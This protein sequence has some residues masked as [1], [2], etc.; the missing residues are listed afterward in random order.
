MIYDWFYLVEISRLYTEY[1][2]VV[3]N[4]SNNLLLESVLD[5][6]ASCRNI[7]SNS[8]SLSRVGKSVFSFILKLKTRKTSLKIVLI[9]LVCRKCVITVLTQASSD[10]FLIQPCHIL[11]MRDCM[12]QKISINIFTSLSRSSVQHM[13]SFF[14]RG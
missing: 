14:V 4:N 7:L 2:S 8:F 11:S 12:P 6:S 3:R 1:F 5:I 10:S 9:R 13:S